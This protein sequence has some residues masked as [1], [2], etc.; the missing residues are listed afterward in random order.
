MISTYQ[1]LG[2]LRPNDATVQLS[3]AQTAESAGNV[4]VEIAALKRV[5][6]LE[7]DQ[8]HQIQAKIKQLQKSQSG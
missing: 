4:K 2:K 3:L 8:A 6:K 5:A 7:P 1:Q